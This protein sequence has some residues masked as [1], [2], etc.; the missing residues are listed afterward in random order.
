[1]PG[2][3]TVEFEEFTK[4]ARLSRDCTVTEKIDGTNAQ[5]YVGEDGEVRAGSRNRWLTVADDN[6]GFAHWVAEHE[7][8]LRQG[9]G[10]GRHFGEWWGSGIQRRYGLDHKRFSL[11]NVARWVDTHG[12]HALQN[13]KQSYA[14]ACCHV[15]PILYKGIFETK[16]IEYLALAPLAEQGS[17]AAPG[18]K[19][20]E[21]VVIWHE[22]ARVLF[23][24]TLLKDEVP[25]SSVS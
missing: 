14:P 5:V 6:F 25:K 15:V 2:S 19:N 11:F 23:K 9:L 4:I 12:N 3:T 10:I 21:G 8:E 7:D 20:P 13:E 18:F 17:I 1:M 22:H 16:A 24:K